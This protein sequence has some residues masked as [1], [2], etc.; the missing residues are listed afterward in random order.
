LDF[1]KETTEKKLVCGENVLHTCTQL[2][3]QGRVNVLRTTASRRGGRKNQ[4]Y[5][6]KI[7]IF[8]HSALFESILKTFIRNFQTAF[9]N[10]MSK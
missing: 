9:N 8:L 10:K 6:R 2:R 5:C 4:R 3:N 7:A 1:F